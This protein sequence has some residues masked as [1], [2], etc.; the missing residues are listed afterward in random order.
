MSKKKFKKDNS[1]QVQQRD[2][3]R[4]DLTIREFKWTDKQKELIELINNKDCKLLF[5]KGKA[6]TSKSLIATYCGLQALNHKRVDEI[7]YTRPILESADS[8]SK[9]GFLPGERKIK[10]EPYL[11]VL[12]EKLEELLPPSQV[13]FLKDNDRI[14]FLEVNFARGRG[15][16]AKFWIIDES[17]GFCWGETVTLLTRIANASKVIICADPDQS[18]LPANK[19]G[20]FEKLFSLF[21]GEDSKKNGIFTFEFGKE[22]ILRSPL[23]KFIVEKLDGH[24]GV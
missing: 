2:K 9:L 12:E 11:E 23:C 20:A 6:G 14:N 7:I 13:N 8:G 19:R 21:S 24:T 3:I 16:A 17:Q 10:T 22:D 15:V 4:S 5:L 1:P 18:D